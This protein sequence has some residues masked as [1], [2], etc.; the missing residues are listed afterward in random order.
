MGTTRATGSRTTGGRGQA[1]GL[2]ASAAQ[3]RSE[4][5]AMDMALELASKGDLA[6]AIGVGRLLLEEID[7][8]E[9]PLGRMAFFR[10]LIEW[11]ARLERPMDCK[12]F[13]SRAVDWGSKRLGEECEAVLIARNSE[14]YWM[15]EVGYDR[16]AARRFPALLRAASEALGEDS[17]LTWAIRVNSAMPYKASGDF[18]GA[19]GVYRD[20]VVDMAERLP[21]DDPLLMTVR[22]NL[23]EAL[24]MDGQYEEAKVI[25]ESLL[26]EALR[27]WGPQDQR[28]LRIRSEIARARFLLG[29]R[30]GAF[31]QWRELSEL[32]ARLL[33]EHHPRTV[34]I[35]SL[36]LAA[37][38][39]LGD[40]ETVVELAER[41]VA[42]PPPEFDVL[43]LEG[44]ALLAEDARA[45]ERV[46]T[47]EGSGGAAGR[48]AEGRGAGE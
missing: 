48:E 34:Q 37:A 27:S 39:D 6:G 10:L 20:L 42:D 5:A 47:R 13:A 44:F 46:R 11:S 22:D 4:R 33:G 26:D 2:G 19:I 16:L 30:E 24:E 17:E 15:C 32:G 3:A 12:R 43:D 9:E 7:E 38:I 45:R 41:F 29:D 31:A 1:F 40:E 25:Y 23:A 28:V 35:L 18:A 21:S 8:S 36:L 14:L